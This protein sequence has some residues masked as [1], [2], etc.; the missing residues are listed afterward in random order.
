MPDCPHTHIQDPGLQDFI[1]LI[2]QETDNG[3]SVVRFFNDA[4]AGQLPNFKPQDRIQAGEVLMRYGSDKAAEYVRAHAAPKPSSN[5]GRGPAPKPPQTQDEA[6]DR[7]PVKVPVIG[8][9]AR[10]IREETENGLTIVRNLVQIM[11]TREDPYQPQHNLK[12]AKQLI[13][14]GFPLPG[15]LLCPPDCPHHSV[16]ALALSA[17][18]ENLPTQDQDEDQRTDEERWAAI[19]ANLKRME[20]EGILT[21]DPN[22]PPIDISSYTMPSYYE[23]DPD[24]LKAEAESF[25]AEVALRVER[26]KQWPEFEE[27]RRKKLAQIY[28]SH[29][30]GKSPD[31]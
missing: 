18:D 12:A 23:C 5:D 21:P 3:A 1:D 11:E 30:D 19:D 17:V 16:E 9:M 2:R 25:K 4:M 20:D 10:I 27:R 28:P 26:R 14:N 22:A 15:A 8:D 6:P 29:S 24:E 7:D 13:D 31:T